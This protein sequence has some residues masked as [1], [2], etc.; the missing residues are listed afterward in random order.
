MNKFNPKVSII[1]PVYNGANFLKEAIDSALAQTYENIEIVVINDGSNDKGATEK[2]AKSYGDKIRYFAKE[3]GGVA[4]AL[5]LGIKKMTGEYFSWLSHDDLYYPNKIEKQVNFLRAA[6]NQKVVLYSNYALLVEG[7]ITPVINHHE[8]LS[9]KKKYS[10]LRGSVNGITLLI[11][12]TILVEMG[13]FK[14]DLRCTQDYEYWVRIQKKYDFVHTEDILSVTRIHGKQDS[15][16]SPLVVSEGNALWI[17]MIKSL[18]NE[19]KI[20]YEGTLYNFYFEMAKFLKGTPY[21]EALELC[22]NELARLMPKIIADQM[23]HK[24]SVVIPFYNRPKQTI[25]SIKSVQNQTHKNIEIVLVNDAS[26]QDISPVLN[27]IKKYKNIVLMNADINRGAAAARN[28]GIKAATGDYIAFLDSDDEFLEGKIKLQLSEMLKHNPDISYTSYVKRSDG[29]DTVM[30]GHGISGVVV[31]RIISS[32]PVATPTVII[33]RKLLIDEGIFFNEAMR[34]GE[35]TCFWL[36]L[37]KSHDIFLI[38]HP[39]T[40]VHAND[41][42][43]AY[44]YDKLVEGMCNI[45]AYLTNDPYYSNFKYD[46][47]LLCND[48]HAL[49]KSIQKE[50]DSNLKI[51]GYD[52]PSFAQKA[53]SAVRRTIPYRLTRKLYKDGPRATYALAIKKLSL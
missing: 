19:E 10:L 43:S 41:A 11:P 50:I 53:M 45:I 16:V 49:N 20:A 34:I 5:N 39:L 48:F 6:K 14:E 37:A 25:N 24:V 51:N 42:S 3:N 4:T 2:I 46:I 47:S 22:N 12:K 31:P 27:Y 32:C 9:R 21:N 23:N 7:R 36:E 13:I 52:V 28:I 29:V 18:P 17:N 35:D 1:I 44:S 33:R 8:M 30:S 26:T 15:A 40:I 38:E